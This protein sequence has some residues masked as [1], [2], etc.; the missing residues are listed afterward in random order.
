VEGGGDGRGAAAVHVV[1]VQ[2]AE[3]VGEVGAVTHAFCVGEEVERRGAVGEAGGF[4]VGD[5]LAGGDDGRG[6]VGEAD[7][8]YW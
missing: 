6:Y 3:P 4:D 1:A 2:A 7:G 8:V 5:F